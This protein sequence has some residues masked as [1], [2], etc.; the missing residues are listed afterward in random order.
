HAP[1]HRDEK[2][3]EFDKSPSGISG[4]DTAL[5]LSLRLLADGVLTINTLTEKMSYNPA[6]IMGLDKGTLRAG[7]DADITI[8]DLNR[9]VIIDAAS[10]ISLGKN[11][12]FD[13]WSIKGMP[14]ITIV[15]G[16]VYE[17]SK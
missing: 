1:H 16:I 17:S 14:V 12:P 13:K 4:L 11:T 6:G 7:A 3:Q 5:G 15:G 2:L 9:E 8:V 10:F